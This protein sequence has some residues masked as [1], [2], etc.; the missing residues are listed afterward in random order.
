MSSV[1]PP[2]A[3]GPY[4][5][6]LH[7]EQ[8]VRDGEDFDRRIAMISYDNAIEVA[9][10]VYLSLNPIQRQ[11]R[12]YDKVKMDSWLKNYHR[13][14]DFL[15]QEI[16]HRKIKCEITKEEIV[17]YH[18]IRNKQY[19]GGGNTIPQLRDLQKIRQIAM[20]IFSFLY[21]IENAEQIV[22]TDIERNASNRLPSKNKDQDV[23]IDKIHGVYE[24][25]GH[26]FY[27]SEILYALDPIL[28]S[29]I[30][31]GVAT[32]DTRGDREEDQS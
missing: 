6:L 5:L 27:T 15:M 18:D 22:L 25:A 8:H 16:K 10:T 1:L 3:Y 9:I 12:K 13:K 2:W 24:I 31:T 23:L 26:N 21:D 19:H 32:E 29:E 14:I 30:A 11:G 17:W 20:W 28:Y 7:A 4:E